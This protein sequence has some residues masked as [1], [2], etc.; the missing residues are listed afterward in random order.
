MWL[1]G[2]FWIL[3]TIGYICN[4]ACSALS[5]PSRRFYGIPCT[6]LQGRYIKPQKTYINNHIRGIVIMTKLKTMLIS[7]VIAMLAITTPVFATPV[8]T[9]NG[10]TEVGSV[11]L[12]FSEKTQDL[13]SA[14]YKPV[15]M[16][17]RYNGSYW[18]M[19]YRQTINAWA[20]AFVAEAQA[21]EGDP[22]D[23]SVLYRSPNEVILYCLDIFNDLDYA[24]GFVQYTVYEFND[25]VDPTT[26]TA[27]FE[28]IVRRGREIPGLNVSGNLNQVLDF[29]GA[30][31]TVLDGT[32]YVFDNDNT[33][34]NW[35]NPA[36]SWVS[37][38]IQVGIWES[39]YDTGLNIDK[40]HFSVNGLSRKGES[41]LDSAFA[42]MTT[43]DSLSRDQVLLFQP[44]SGGQTLIG[45]PD[46]S[47]IP[48]PG[49]AWLI[50]VGLVGLV[51][52]VKIRV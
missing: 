22:F 14:G 40:G 20:G 24:N 26:S 38:A 5:G 47:S 30:V 25:T 39:L 6:T 4:H 1:W 41:L 19:L 12:G 46:M 44:V 45:D 29:L 34:R 11:E 10:M 16:N 18:N 13:F 2:I 51:G 42:Q 35:L 33:D 37:S 17:I 48:L 23:P 28:P 43:T 21:I 36:Y 15:T 9:V 7:S 3:T 8:V 52:A 31:N 49:T 27:L 50:L 32:E